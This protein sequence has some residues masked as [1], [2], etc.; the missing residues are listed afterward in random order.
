MLSALESSLSATAEG[1]GP[2]MRP[3]EKN[4]RCLSQAAAP[5]LYGRMYAWGQKNGASAALQLAGNATAARTAKNAPDGYS[6]VRLEG[7]VGNP[8]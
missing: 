3:P 2:E 1:K 7:R 8:L 4:P 6:L 5:L